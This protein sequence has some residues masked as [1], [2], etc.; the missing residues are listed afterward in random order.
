MR[1]AHGI[2]QKVD[3]FVHFYDHLSFAQ[4]KLNDKFLRQIK[5]LPNFLRQNLL[6]NKPTR[7]NIL[8]Q[9]TISSDKWIH[10]PSS[11]H[12]YRNS[13]GSCNFVLTK[14]MHTSK[15]MINSCGKWN[16]KL[17]AIHMTYKLFARDFGTQGALNIIQYI[18]PVEIRKLVL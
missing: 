10:V 7:T 13:I 18:L 6:C 11:H 1:G 9:E 3:G 16:N 8:V 15:H 12:I 14:S 5:K 2:N 17:N 4:L